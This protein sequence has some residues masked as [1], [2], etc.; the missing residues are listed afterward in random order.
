MQCSAQTHA[1]FEPAVLQSSRGPMPQP[2]VGVDHENVHHGAAEEAQRAAAEAAAARQR[3]YAAHGWNINNLPRHRGSVLRYLEGDELITGVQARA[4][5]AQ[6]WT[7]NDDWLRCDLCVLSDVVVGHG[8]GISLCMQA[9]SDILPLHS[10][11]SAGLPDCLAQ[12]P[13][14]QGSV[15]IMR[16]GCELV[17]NTCFTV[18]AEVSTCWHAHRC[19]GCTSGLCCRRSAGTWRT[20]PC[21]AST[22]ITWAR[23]RCVVLVG[24]NLA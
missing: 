3:E 10:S 22:I 24:L 13:S 15:V 8:K 14:F 19:R 7:T 4:A 21:T 2:S 12:G 23:R 11:Q 9:P 6:S 18:K 20:T 5:A 17:Y 16:L 1:H